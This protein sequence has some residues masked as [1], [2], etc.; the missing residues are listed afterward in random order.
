MSKI[1]HYNVNKNH[2]NVCANTRLTSQLYNPANTKTTKY[3]LDT[4]RNFGSKICNISPDE[5]NNATGYSTNKKPA[6]GN[7]R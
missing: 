7:Q 4:L 1:F 5:I 6:I 2:D 3:G